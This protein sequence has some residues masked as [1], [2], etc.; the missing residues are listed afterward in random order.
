VDESVAGTVRWTYT[1]KTFHTEGGTK[2]DKKT[3]VVFRKSDADA[4][5]RMVEVVYE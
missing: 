2:F 1:G 3:V 4:P 5:A